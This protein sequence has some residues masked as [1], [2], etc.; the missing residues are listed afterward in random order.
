LTA[1]TGRSL[2]HPTH[3]DFK[4]GKFVS[5]VVVEFDAELDKALRAF[6]ELQ[7]GFTSANIRYE[8]RDTR[9]K[10]SRILLF[11]DPTKLPPQ[12]T[13]EFNIERRAGRPFSENRYFS[14]AA[15]PTA[16]HLDLLKTFECRLL[17]G[18]LKREVK[19]IRVSA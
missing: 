2:A 6:G 4:R 7:E 3:S 8:S 15:L 14:S 17:I 1:P 12:A 16:S 11:A 19:T 13:F 18:L 5:S 9:L 10:A